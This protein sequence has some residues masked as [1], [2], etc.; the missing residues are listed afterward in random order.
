MSDTQTTPQISIVLPTKNGARYLISSIESI[1]AQTHKDWELIIVDDGSTDESPQIAASWARRDPRVTTVSLAPSRGLPGALNEGFKHARGELWTWTSDD[2]RYEAGALDR[3][4]ELLNVDS[5]IDFVYSDYHTIDEEGKRRGTT[6]VGPASDLPFC[7]V[8]GPCFLYRA[9]L[10]AEI[11]GYDES[12]ALAEDYDF[13]LRAAL[14]FRL[15]PIHQ[16][17]YQ[18]RI[19]SGSLTARHK[20]G[21]LKAAQRVVDRQMHAFTPEVQASI[22]IRRAVAESEQGRTREARRAALRVVVR[23]PQILLDDQNRHHAVACL[24]RPS[25]ADALRTGWRWISRRRDD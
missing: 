17:L 4:S 5:S 15:E 9:E 3:M 19:H 11:E 7:N 14:R 18:Y 12:A 10:H 6:S 2:N 13:W 24:L 16:P 23:R 8:V 22:L 25:V 21:I 20:D 1:V